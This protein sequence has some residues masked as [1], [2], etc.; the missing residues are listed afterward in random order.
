VNYRIEQ[1]STVQCRYSA[2]V[3]YVPHSCPF[4][5]LQANNRIF[6]HDTPERRGER[7]RREKEERER[8]KEEIRI[9]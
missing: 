1:Y 9:R 7:K 4:S 5:R 2:G 3:Q 6:N 8:E